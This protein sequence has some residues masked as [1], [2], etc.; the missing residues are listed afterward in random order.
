MGTFNLKDIHT[1]GTHENAAGI[2]EFSS[3]E[4]F[5][6]TVARLRKENKAFLL[7]GG[8]SNVLFS[9][10]YPG[11]ILLDRTQ[12]L[13]IIEE[14][15]HS[16]L[17]RIAS[18]ENWHH[19][20]S[21]CV[22]HNLGGIE[23]LALIPGNAGAAPIQNIGAYG[24]E[25]AEVLDS[26]SFY[27]I[28]DLRKATYKREECQ[29]AY[30][31]SIFKTALKNKVWIS[32]IVLRLTRGNHNLNTG[33]SALAQL[34]SQ[35]SN[36]QSLTIQ[37]IYHAVIAIRQSKLP[38]PSK[39]G[40]AGSFFKNPVIDHNDYLAL[41]AE[42]P[43]LPGWPVFENKIKVPAGW[44]IEKTGLKGYRQGDAGI[45]E[46]HALVLINYGNATG[47]EI[48]DL[49]KLVMQEVEKRFGI[50]LEPEVNIV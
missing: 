1:F 41:K 5:K 15:D 35:R 2:T 16:V 22:E 19:V 25:L 18:G 26:V 43:D 50:L 27:Y 9:T 28:N 8:G 37:D 45:H 21:Y 12:G 10:A 29:F 33:Y 7:L 36:G 47:G 44:L 24:T 30:R 42:F 49:A 13:E 11:F 32:E 17:L 46:K 4:E 23:N 48:L 34:L 40:N 39:L 20:V 38:D 31:S 14:N 6:V 3:V